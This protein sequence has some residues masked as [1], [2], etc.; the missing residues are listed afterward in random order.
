MISTRLSISLC[1]WSIAAIVIISNLLLL[2]VHTF[3]VYHYKW[4]CGSLVNIS[5]RIKLVHHSFL[6]WGWFQTYS[7]A[8]NTLIKLTLTWVKLTGWKIVWTLLLLKWTLIIKKSM[9]LVWRHDLVF[10]W[11]NLLFLLQLNQSGFLPSW[12]LCWYDW[13]IN[14]IKWWSTWGWMIQALLAIGELYIFI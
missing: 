14:F 5:T 9:L 11:W 4:I 1:L 7:A 8:L 2:A 13:L 10:E 12:I 3:S 6:S